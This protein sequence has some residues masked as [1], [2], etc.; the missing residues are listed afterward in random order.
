MLDF[1]AYIKVI[2]LFSALAI[3]GTIILRR[4]IRNNHPQLVIPAGVIFGIGLFIFLINLLAHIIKGIPSFYVV[5]LLQIAIALW[6]HFKIPVQ[7]FD[8]PKGKFLIY[9]LLSF[10]FWVIFLYQITAH[11]IIDGADSTIY[12][13]LAARFVRGDYPIHT[14][15]QPDY[16]A[17]NHIGG[18]QFL[19]AAKALT[20]A[21][22]YFL[23][24]FLAFITLLSVSQILTW[25]F[26]RNINSLF[27]FFLI[28]LPAITGIITL[29][30]FMLA[31]PVSLHIPQFY[32]LPTLNQS[33]EVYGSAANLDA[34]VLFLH[35]F[36]STSLLIALLVPILFP[37]NRFTVV[38][39]SLL[40]ATIALVDESVFIVSIIPF[41]IAT[42]FTV[43]KKSIKACLIF[44]VL[45]I[46]LVSAQGGVI[47]ESLLNRYGES[48]SILFFPKDGVRKTENYRSYRLYQQETRIFDNASYLPL[49]WLHPAIYLQILLLFILTLKFWKSSDLHNR[50]ILLWILFATSLISLVAYHG[51]V[52]KGY[53]HPNGNRFLT[54]AFYLSGL[55]IAFFISW[56]FEIK[57][58]GK[59]LPFFIKGLVV[60]ILITSIIPPFAQFF[61]RKKDNFLKI[62]KST[63][64]P[65]FE[66]IKN[67]IDKDRRIL[68]LVD[69]N[70]IPASNL[71]LVT[72]AGASTPIWA[73]NIRVHDS[74]DMSPTYADFYYTLNP[75]IF[76]LL[77][78]NY[79]LT[80]NQ[81]R[82]SL[83]QKRQIDLT[84]PDFFKPVFTNLGT[85]IIIYEMQEN[86]LTEGKN[87]EGTFTQLAGIAPLDG[88]YYIDYPPNISENVFRALRLLLYNRNVYCNRQ[89]GFYN[90]RIDIEIDK[91]NEGAQKYDYLV[92]GDTVNPETICHCKTTLIWAGLG[93][94]VKFWKT[95]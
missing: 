63:P 11:S 56:F 71:T 33:F 93:N 84:N 25:L 46:L 45:L 4:F 51:I 87:L 57:L 66:W 10:S 43:F 61:P 48:S 59:L 76:K 85:D 54:L 53:T 52:P 24:A 94:G 72:E 83:P 12:Y 13:S 3:S 75:Q 90:Q 36:L 21:P 88:T 80:S 27:G 70:P 79:I 64:N 17:Y 1:L 15:W 73:P 58:K 9:L 62:N 29:G 5:I 19:A 82:S 65:I 22:F 95:Q 2:I 20:G 74:F 47:T 91:C 35:R 41:L 31:F 32:N 92:L 89:G 28:S 55:G 69:T 68:A 7:K 16:I 40:I 44:S 8:Y 60:W 77:R 38:I 37:K 23:H 14:P 49:Q 30:S 18:P 34:L 81:Y 50:K 42:Y 67:N 86:F 39:L 6:V 78:V 26:V